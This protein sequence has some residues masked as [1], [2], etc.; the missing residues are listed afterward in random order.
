MAAQGPRPE[1]AGGRPRSVSS[2]ARAVRLSGLGARRA[3]GLSLLRGVREGA[4]APGAGVL[5]AGGVPLPP[6]RQ[7]LRVFPEGVLGSAPQVR[8]RLCL[9]LLNGHSSAATDKCPVGSNV[10]FLRVWCCVFFLDAARSSWK[11]LR[12]Q[13]LQAEGK[14]TGDDSLKQVPLENCLLGSCP[15]FPR[16][17]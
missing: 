1:G 12:S 15:L 7:R 6:R 17:V 4:G 2:R 9:L 13:Y 11:V 16:A 8:T 5:P 10:V 3:A 14:E